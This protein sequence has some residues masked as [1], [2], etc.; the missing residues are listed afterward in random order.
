M[1]IR[2]ETKIGIVVLAAIVLFVVGFYFLKGIYIFEKPMIYHSV[3]AKINGLETSNPVMI[4]GYK[5]GQVKSIDI[6]KG[7]SGKLLV[8]MMVYEDVGIPKDSKALLKPG[9]LLGSMQLNI[10]L[11]QSL[12][13]AQSGDTLDPE[14]SGDLFEEVNEQL[15][16]IKIKAKTLL[17]SVDSVLNVIENILNAESQQSIV[18]SFKGINNAVNNLERAT[19]TIDTLVNQERDRIS[20]IFRNIEELSAVLNDNGDELENIVDNFS[21][22]S[23]SLAKA[24][25]AATIRQANDALIEVD[26]IVKKINKGEGSLGML[27]NNPSLYNRLDSAANNLDLLVEDI[28]VNPNRYV[29]FSVFGRKNKNVELTRKEMEQLKEFIKES[30]AGE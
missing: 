16:P 23:D 22:I 24:D 18:E 17:S 7:G 6:L 10:V 21:Q 30:E 25:V 20:N 27:I 2:K 9:D 15:R 28:R 14:I 19:F 4:N 26:E 3:Y 11:G 12:E 8:T 1:A 13:L 29:Q 5:V